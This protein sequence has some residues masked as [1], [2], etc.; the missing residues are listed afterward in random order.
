MEW[1]VVAMRAKQQVL[2][3]GGK[4]QKMA[5]GLCRKMPTLKRAVCTRSRLTH[6]KDHLREDSALNQPR[7]A[8]G[9]FVVH[10]HTKA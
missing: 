2:G 9:A 4:Q 5:G 7:D 8:T 1:R 10:V 3:R 6:N